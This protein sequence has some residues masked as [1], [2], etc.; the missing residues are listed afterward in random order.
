LGL[1]K[2]FRFRRALMKLTLRALPITFFCV[3]LACVAAL[4]QVQPAPDGPIHSRFGLPAS[5]MKAQPKAA[6]NRP[7]Q[8]LGSPDVSYTFGMVDFPG[9]MD[10]GGSAANDKGEIIG[11]Y[12][13]DMVGDTVSNYGFLLKGPSLPGSIIR[14]RGGLSRTGSATPARS[15]ANTGHPSPGLN[16]DSNWL[17]KTTPLLPTLA[18]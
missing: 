1:K 11:G 13:P 18:R 8:T 2:I 17:A 16:R 12:G 5:R 10:S 15:S 9:Q 14:A 7:E 3:S 6:A 4:A